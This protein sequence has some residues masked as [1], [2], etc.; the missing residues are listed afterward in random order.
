[1]KRTTK[2]DKM[3]FFK[4]IKTIINNH[5]IWIGHLSEEGYYGDLVIWILFYGIIL[6]F[7]F[8]WL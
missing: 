2:T 6:Y 7:G 1:M 5:I 4:K 3:N 8:L